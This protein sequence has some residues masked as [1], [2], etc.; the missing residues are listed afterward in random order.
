MPIRIRIRIG[1]KMEFQIQIGLKTIHN[2]TANPIYKFSDFCFETA[3][4][5]WPA[6]AGHICRWRRSWRREWPRSGPATQ[7]ASPLRAPESEWEAEYAGLLSAVQGWGSGM[8]IPDPNV[9]HPGSWI[10]IFSIPDS[11]LAEI[12]SGLLIPNPDPGSCF[13]LPIPGPGSRLQKDTGSRIR[14]RNTAALLCAWGTGRIWRFLGWYEMRNNYS[15]SVYGSGS[16]TASVFYILADPGCL[17]RIPDP[18]F[19]PS[20]TPDPGSRI[21]DPKTA[22]KERSEKKFVVITFYVP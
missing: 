7:S 14:I 6:W 8:F 11:K 12:W 19:Y 15:V 4:L 9:F 18:D 21:P 17:C 10:R 22:T 16:G 20:R 5:G 1:F 2:T 13:F 3:C